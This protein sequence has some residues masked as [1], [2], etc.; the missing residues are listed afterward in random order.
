[1]RAKKDAKAVGAGG[2]W[3]KNYKRRKESIVAKQKDTNNNRN[4]N[5]LE[6]EKQFRKAN[7]TLNRTKKDEEERTVSWKQQ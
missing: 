6:D 5:K 7:E 4:N 3:E 1:M 2:G